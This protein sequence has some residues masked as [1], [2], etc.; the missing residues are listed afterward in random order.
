MAQFGDIL[1]DFKK[2]AMGEAENIFPIMEDETLVNGLIAWKSVKI[3]YKTLLDCPHKDEAGQWEWLWEQ[4][5][6]NSS[7]F[8]AVAGVK[9]QDT[10]NLLTR[11]KGLRLIYPDGT[12]NVLAKQYLQAQIMGKIRQATKPSREP[13]KEPAKPAE[14]KPA[15][16]PS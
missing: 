2:M 16:K 3:N 15:E 4:V 8:G 14:P 13:A 11:L 10:G 12:I 5:E 1:A 9:M 7:Q 6:F